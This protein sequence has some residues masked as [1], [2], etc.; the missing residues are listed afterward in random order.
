MSKGTMTK[1]QFSLR[2]VLDFRHLRVDVERA[3]LDR[4][5]LEQQQLLDQERA[6]LE[7]RNREE[8]EVRAPGAAL[9]MARLESLDQMQA[10]VTVARRRFAEEHAELAA[11]IRQ[12]EDVVLEAEREVG[13]LEKLEA[14]QRAEWQG[15]FDKELEGLAADSYLSRYHRQTKQKPT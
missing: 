13:L 11:R 12:Q 6:L 2:R 7:D 8:W 9:T 3:A 1:F 10:Y 15:R 4:L 5:R 14:R